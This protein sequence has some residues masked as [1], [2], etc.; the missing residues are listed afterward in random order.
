[1][2]KNKTVVA[3]KAPSQISLLMEAMQSE[4]EP[5]VRLLVKKAMLLSTDS[6]K[7][8]PRL[9]AFDDKDV[10]AVTHLIQSIK[11]KDGIETI[12]ASQFVALHLKSM[13]IMSEDN[14]NIMGAGLSMMRLSHNALSMLQQYRCKSQIINVNNIHS[15]GDTV[16]NSLVQAGMKEKSEVRHE[17]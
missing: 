5:A 12:I 4:H 13:K 9:D 14:Y 7:T 6:A 17:S 10:D 2:K 11:P 16:L 8:W 3:R 15:E 1:M